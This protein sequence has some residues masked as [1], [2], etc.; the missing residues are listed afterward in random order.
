MEIPVKV[1]G[2]EMTLEFLVGNF[3]DEAILGMTDLRKLGLTI[4][5][6]YS[7][8]SKGEYCIPVHDMDNHQLSTQ[9]IL[10]STVT[11]PP[12]S[13]YQVMGQVR[14]RDI[15]ELPRGPVMLQPVWS[16]MQKYGI[17]TGKSLHNADQNQV[18]VL[19]FNSN[20]DSVV[21]D[22]GTTI[23]VLAPVEEIQHQVS[24]TLSTRVK[25]NGCQTKPCDSV[26]ELP[27]HVTDLYERSCQHLQERDKVKLK[28]FLVQYSDFSPSQILI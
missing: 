23:G 26:Q 22:S 17:L 10:Q 6:T 1:C 28:L 5:F 14:S 15:R 2:S 25:A 8:V 9:V 16:V 12:K 27:A 13:E 11:V 21:L 24:D 20:E 19:L 18:P 7:K 4:D 3:S